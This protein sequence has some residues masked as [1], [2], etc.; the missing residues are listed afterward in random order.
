MAILKDGTN[1]GVVMV[2][3]VPHARQIDLSR[4]DSTEQMTEMLSGR[5]LEVVNRSFLQSML[6]ELRELRAIVGEQE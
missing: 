3:G 6:N 2:D 1:D 4:I 5:G